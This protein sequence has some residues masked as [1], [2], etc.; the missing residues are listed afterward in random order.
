MFWMFMRATSIFATF[1]WMSWK[2]P[3]G[4]PN[5]TR[6]F[7][8]AM[9][10]FKHSSKMPSAI[11]L[12]TELARPLSA[13]GT[14]RASGEITAIHD[15]GQGAVVVTETESVDAASGELLFRTRSAVF[16]RGAGGFGGDR[17]P[18]ALHEPQTRKPDQGATLRRASDRSGA[19]RADRSFA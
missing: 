5:C 7:A 11:E 16:I 2:S 14:L 1:R 15:K 6:V 19:T 9:L 8:Y 17:G 12:A 10:S 3:I 13:E 4:R 18:S